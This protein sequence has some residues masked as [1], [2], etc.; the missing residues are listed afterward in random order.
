M[1]EK[2]PMKSPKLRQLA[3][4]AAALLAAA[5]F[6]YLLVQRANRTEYDFGDSTPYTFDSSA[7]QIFRVLD[8]R[9]AVASSSGIQLLDENGATVLHE[10]FSLQNPGMAAGSDRVAVFDIGGTRLTVADFEGDT[11]DVAAAGTIVTATMNAGGYLTVVTDAAG[12]KGLV[13]VYDAQREPV[14]E[15]YSGTGYVLTAALSDD[16]KHLAVLCADETGSTVHLFTL[17]SE[18]ETGSYAAPGELFADL[19]W[20]SGGRVCAVSQTRLAFLNDR[21]ELAAQYDYGGMYL[22]DYAKEGDGYATLVLSQ[23]RSGSAASIVTV[24]AN[25]VLQGQC[26]PAVD[27]ESVS[28]AG[29]QVLVF[30]SGTLTLYNQQM[31]QLK[32]AQEDLLGVK[33]AV[34]LGR[35]TVLLVYGYSAQISEF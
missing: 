16:G 26:T 11:A 28:V 6:V 9:L 31:E 33:R 35:G 14:Y 22:Y 3:I 29:K 12:Y 10:L 15:W 13:T 1:E 4:A 2:T 23:Y 8:S 30:G 19:Y 7:H 18:E 21:A 27:V 25:G 5:L 24:N 32:A 20:I 17:G 34:L